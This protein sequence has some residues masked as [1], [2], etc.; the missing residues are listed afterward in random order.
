MGKKGD[1]KMMER[2]SQMK[3]QGIKRRSGS[4][5][6]GCGAS[7]ANGGASLMAHLNTCQGKM[8]K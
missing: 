6:M 7:I 2:A 1:K 8:R 4:C 3:K 5:P